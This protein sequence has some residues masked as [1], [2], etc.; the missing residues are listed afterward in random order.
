M[1]PRYN[2]FIKDQELAKTHRLSSDD[3]LYL[4]QL[5]KFN[6]IP[7]YVLINKEGKVLNDDF[8]MHNLKDELKKLIANNY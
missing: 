7:R 8:P 6:G 5:F 4:R 1:L 2:D 3:F